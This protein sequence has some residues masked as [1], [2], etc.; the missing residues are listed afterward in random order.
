MTLW[1]AILKARSRASKPHASYEPPARPWW[2]DERRLHLTAATCT[3]SAGAKVFGRN[4]NRTRT[5]AELLAEMPLCELQVADPQKKKAE[6]VPPKDDIS[7]SEPE[8]QF[9]PV[10]LLDLRIVERKAALEVN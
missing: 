3:A 4:R 5:T 2:A 10:C 9:F 7:S 8:D 6:S 1:G